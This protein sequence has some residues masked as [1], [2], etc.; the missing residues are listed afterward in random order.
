MQQGREWRKLKKRI[1]VAGKGTLRKT[2]LT[3][4]VILSGCLLASCGKKKENKLT[5]Y[6]DD[7]QESYYR[8]G[9][10]DFREAYPDVE[11]ELE[12]HD[13]TGPVS[14]EQ[15]A[16]TQ[17]MAGEGP[18]LL[19][20]SNL[21]FD[22]V[23]K[24]MAAGAF[25]PLDEFMEADG[26]DSGDYVETVMDAGRFDGRQYVMPLS[27]S[28]QIVLSSEEALG[29]AGFD[30]GA[31]T[32]MVSLMKQISGLY[33][34]DY[35][36]QILADRSLFVF[37]PQQL[38]GEF[39]DYKTGEIGTDPDELR[40]ACEAYRNIFDEDS[41]AD[42]L[43]E[44]GYY[45]QGTAILERRAYITA[46]TTMRGVLQPMAAIAAEETPV[47][48]PVSKGDG[49]TIAQILRYAGIR[50][51]SENKENAWRMLRILM[52]GEMQERMADNIGYVPVLKSAIDAK[53]REEVAEAEGG[54]D[55]GVETGEI[56]GE[57]LE[58][59]IGYLK[60]PGSAMFPSFIARKFIETMIPYLHGEAEY[61][62]CLEEFQNYAKI[63]LTE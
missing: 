1:T 19:L 61:D 16:K 57:L 18:D 2:V 55:D 44:Q 12:L 50:A 32:D 47:L 53:I 42:S 26:W 23:Y 54:G 58:Q 15:K 63:Y 21:G 36:Q 35:K 6:M 37:F 5:V 56:S 11:L 33:E 43:L 41:G 59:Y 60:E 25:A 51:N 52:G 28:Q 38:K 39:L 7:F 31:C 4:A 10:E 48:I 14:E 49:K 20:F 46:L 27:Y 22:D 30:T 24:Y 9:I 13:A 3:L 62:D 34:R 29:E 45:S 17:M 8:E 40:A